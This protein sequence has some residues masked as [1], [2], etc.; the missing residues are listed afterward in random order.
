MPRTKKAEREAVMA[1]L[2]HPQDISDLDED[3]DILEDLKSAAERAIQAL[4]EARTQHTSKAAN[5]PWVVLIQ[6]KGQPL[7]H[8]YGPY[9][10]QAQAHKA[11]QGLV[12][13]GPQ[14]CWSQVQRLYEVPS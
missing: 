6:Q 9:E 12:C 11:L 2:I 4:T 3:E 10:T 8:T 7:V 5:R 14:P 13:P 1:A